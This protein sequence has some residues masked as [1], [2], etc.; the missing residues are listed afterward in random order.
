[1]RRRF[2]VI[3]ATIVLIAIGA[4]IFVE[5]FS[6]KRNSETHLIHSAVQLN[7]GLQQGIVETAF[8]LQ[9]NLI[10]SSALTPVQQLISF[11]DSADSAAAELRQNSHE[12]RLLIGEDNAVV[13][14]QLR[15]LDS[16]YSAP[17][18][19]VAGL[20]DTSADDIRRTLPP[21]EIRILIH[22]LV[23]I[24]DDIE[25]CSQRI[26]GWLDE[27][28]DL[29]QANILPLEI[30]VLL[31][32][33]LLLFFLSF[34]T[35]RPVYRRL[36]VSIERISESEKR[37]RTLVDNIPNG[38][39][40][41]VSRDYRHLELSG[42]AFQAEDST[43]SGDENK[44]IAE[45]LQSE[46]LLLLCKPFYQR[47]FAGKNASFELEFGG[48]VWH[49]NAVPNREGEAEFTTLT[50]IFQDVTKSKLAEA[51]IKGA[52][53]RAQELNEIKSR[54]VAT[55]SHEFR[56]PLTAI[57]NSS[58]FLQRFGE[59]SDPAKVSKHFGYIDDS[60]RR[61]KE[62]LED[63][64]FTSKADANKVLVKPVPLNLRAWCQNLRDE[65]QQERTHELL[66]KISASVRAEY[67][68]D[69]KLLR[70]CL[71]NLLSNAFKYSPAGSP[72]EFDVSERDGSLEF[73]IRDYGIGIEADDRNRLF[74]SFFRG[75][76]VGTIRGTGLGLGIAG[77]AALALG[78]HIDVSSEA[79][80]GSRF[81]LTLP[82]A[83]SKEKVE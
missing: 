19:L 82:L 29:Q 24:D 39:V 20:I 57:H 10:D 67:E 15:R 25:Q 32:L 51:E 42:T 52:L 13:F 68:L 55:V 23:A 53:A 31:I 72:V 38:G 2:N 6:D 71:S 41:L 59:R 45:Y 35:F 60:V 7:S 83:S 18:E 37:Y 66:L 50:A 47:A 33:F 61:M 44:D 73:G 69:D 22:Q 1:M 14:E 79:G 5:S 81:V 49:W 80:N 28:I 4:L 74:E 54:F 46:E 21:Q 65:M 56:S 43:P 26:L 76:N 3:V 48:R 77:H 63:V 30:A 9:T 36:D 78:G 62:L 17:A 27:D 75:A 16:L 70:R 12:L 11:L 64:L 8:Q 40:A 34:S 58:Q